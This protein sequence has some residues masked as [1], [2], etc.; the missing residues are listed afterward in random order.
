MGRR[1]HTDG[2]VEFMYGGKH[3]VIRQ[4]PNTSVPNIDFGPI[5]PHEVLH[6]MSIVFDCILTHNSLPFGSI[7]CYKML[8]NVQNQCCAARAF[9]RCVSKPD[10]MKVMKIATTRFDTLAWQLEVLSATGLSQ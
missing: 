2:L 6:Y 5:H 8:S 10:W 4:E 1:L 3:R 9:V 7:R